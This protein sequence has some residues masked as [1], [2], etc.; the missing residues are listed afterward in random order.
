[1][2]AKTTKIWCYFTS[3]VWCLSLQVSS[4]R[5]G[6]N[7]N[8]QKTDLIALFSPTI[9]INWCTNKLVG[10]WYGILTYFKDADS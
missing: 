8:F 6:C 3:P 4:G 9:D 5:C 2:T 1:M 7:P 10:N